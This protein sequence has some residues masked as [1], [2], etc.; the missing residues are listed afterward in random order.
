VT[1]RRTRSWLLA[2]VALA[3]LSCRGRPA[4]V[5]PEPQRIAELEPTT[6]PAEKPTA[7]EPVPAPAIAMPEPP[8]EPLA[9][10]D[11]VDPRLLGSWCLHRRETHG[12]SK[13]AGSQWELNP[14]FTFSH[15]HP[16]GIESGTWSHSRRART[17][18]LSGLGWHRIRELTESSLVL[19]DALQQALHFERECSREYK[20]QLRV[21][22]LVAAAESEPLD[23]ICEALERGV[24]LNAIDTL[25]AD[26]QTALMAAARGGR[27]EVVEL[28][29]KRGARHET[30]AG[31]ETAMSLAEKNG[32][33]QV[34]AALARAGAASDHPAA[35]EMTQGAPSAPPPRPAPGRALDGVHE[36][37]GR[38]LEASDDESRA[39]IE[40]A[41]EDIERR[42][43]EEPE[44][45][46]Q[47]R[48]DLARQR[49]E[50]LT[51]SIE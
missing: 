44:M 23:T 3:S 18:E 40:R 51:E 30:E 42:F 43:P 41:I 37:L 25:S 2:C 27:R 19:E 15:G 28:L 8:I 17:L 47:E 4:E 32:H 26:P 33:D 35:R 13:A 14:D 16:P 49:A 29:L 5:E 36:L 50:A 6:L 34:I 39:R 31:G 45:T 21:R 1:S 12:T 20:S 9:E 24:D 22:A 46:E 48:R 38:A 10:T 7:E 11:E